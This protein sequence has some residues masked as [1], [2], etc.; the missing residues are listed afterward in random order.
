M[1]N[2]VE[3]HIR[4]SFVSVCD[5]S[6]SLRYK[7]Q[8]NKCQTA[9]VKLC[10]VRKFEAMFMMFLLVLVKTRSI[11]SFYI[12]HRFV[13]F[14]R[15]F[16]SVSESLDLLSRASLQHSIPASISKSLESQ[17]ESVVAHIVNPRFPE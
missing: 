16:F 1:R 4:E 15:K 8:C 9:D 10:S 5:V 17:T 13:M 12:N 2:F 11:A 6:V 7:L 14:E 3:R